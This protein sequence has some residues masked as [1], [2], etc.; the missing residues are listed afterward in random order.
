MERCKGCLVS[1]NL[2]VWQ[3]YV[4]SRNNLCQRSSLEDRELLLPS[5]S[6]VWSSFSCPSDSKTG[7]CP[8]SGKP[9]AS[10]QGT[11]WQSPSYA[12]FRIGVSIPPPIGCIVDL[13]ASIRRP[14]RFSCYAGCGNSRTVVCRGEGPILNVP[15]K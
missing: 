6:F 9:T 5:A 15:H 7:Q 14:R 11:E 12:L 2:S 4:L 10:I 1:S 3:R 13:P 8:M